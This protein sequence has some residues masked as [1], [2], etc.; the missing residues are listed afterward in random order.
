MNLSVFTVFLKN[1]NFTSK[2]KR[3]KVTDLCS[4]KR[5]PIRNELNYQIQ[6][7]LLVEMFLYSPIK[8]VHVIPGI[9]SKSFTLS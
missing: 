5:S 7:Y 6:K 9:V 4:F 1:R 8:T 3:S 2:I